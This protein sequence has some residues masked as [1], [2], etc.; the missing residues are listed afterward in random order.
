MVLVPAQTV[1]EGVGRPAVV[2]STAHQVRRAR[3]M[4]HLLLVAAELYIVQWRESGGLGATL[5]REVLRQPARP[6]LLRHPAVSLRHEVGVLNNSLL[7]PAHAST[8]SS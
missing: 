6:E 2:L 7:R 5:A 8:S 1:V 4:L 3:A